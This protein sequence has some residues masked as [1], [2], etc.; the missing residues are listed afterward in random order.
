V[1][2]VTASA[3]SKGRKNATKT[4]VCQIDSYRSVAWLNFV[5]LM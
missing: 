2:K 3:E 5:R 1:L 4:A